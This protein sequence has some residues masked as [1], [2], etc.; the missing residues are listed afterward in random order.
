[1]L[2]SGYQIERGLHEQSAEVLIDPL[3]NL[4]PIVA[5]KAED[6]G[7]PAETVAA[8]AVVDGLRLRSAWTNNSIPWGSGGIPASGAL[9]VALET[10][11]GQLDDTVDA[12]ADLL[13]SESVFQLVRGSTPAT[14]AIARFHGAGRAPA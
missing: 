4:Y 7:D 1:V 12:V 14:A 9:R 13:L 2:C 8:R 5:N 6:S 10:L 11:L 3:R